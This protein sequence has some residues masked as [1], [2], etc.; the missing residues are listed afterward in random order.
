MTDRDGPLW[1]GRFSTPPAPEA[2]E[3]G[4]SL[5]FDV[6]LAPQDVEAS[7]A[8]AR[9]LEEAGVL[10]ADGASQLEK[11]I[12][13]VGASVADGSFAFHAADEDVHSAIERGVT[14]RL[15]DLGAK[16]H[17]G[18]SR[19]DL[20]MTD[21]RLWLMAATA[22]IDEGLARLIRALVGHARDHAET[23]MPGIDARPPRP[24]GHARPSSVR[25]RVGPPA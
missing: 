22:R 17:A 2:Q 16:L 7:V 19:N 13:E 5:G 8:H 18:R 3:L 25:A 12:A 20:V 6:R 21:L 14:E 10:T 23:V 9:A 1:A 15:G 24:A 4:R 11:A